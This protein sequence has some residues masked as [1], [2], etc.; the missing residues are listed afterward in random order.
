MAAEDVTMSAVLECD[1]VINPEDPDVGLRKIFKRIRPNWAAEKIEFKS[2]SKEG[3]VNTLLLATHDEDI[4]NA[5]VIRIYSSSFDSFLDRKREVAALKVFNE[6]GLSPR[7]YC[8][9]KNGVC[10]QYLQ[11][12]TWPWEELTAGEF[13]NVKIMR[14][15]AR[16]LARYH[17]KKTSDIALGKYG[18]MF[19]WEV[20][21][22]AIQ[23]KVMDHWPDHGYGDAKTD[24]IFK[25]Y[26]SKECWQAAVNEIMVALRDNGA[27]IAMCHLDATPVNMFYMAEE[28][29]VIFFD[30]ELSAFNFTPVDFARFLQ[31][32]ASGL[33]IDLSDER[34]HS[35][36]VRSEFFRAYLEEQK[37]LGDFDRDITEKE[38]Q[39]LSVLT[40]KA[41]L[42]DYLFDS[43]MTIIIAQTVVVNS[44]FSRK[45]LIEFAVK[46]Y[47]WYKLHK[48][49]IL[50][51]EVPM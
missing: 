15:A 31:F 8:V 51:L 12:R 45:D 48:E 9:F 35:D 30:Y 29:R 14:A 33:D 49:R 11:G 40:D 4:S 22:I 6:R 17:S 27:P 13:S 47:T 2:L 28:D 3:F 7:T 38:V 36:A 26:P 10:M 24:E 37:L 18:E 1:G 23:K 20:E 21:M 16:E 39:R 32:S 25:Q 41:V 5:V 42:A 19:S 44:T 43:A 46:E 50:A 34:R